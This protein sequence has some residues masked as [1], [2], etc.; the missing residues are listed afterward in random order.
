MILNK[1]IR[2]EAGDY[3]YR[4]SIY[5]NEII[6]DTGFTVDVYENICM[7]LNKMGADPLI[8]FDCLD[9]YKH[10]F[11]EVKSA[12][13]YGDYDDITKTLEGGE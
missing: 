3:H 10:L 1:E 7:E 6:K 2:K 11:E 4:L 5:F 13:K 9:V 12:R 8:S